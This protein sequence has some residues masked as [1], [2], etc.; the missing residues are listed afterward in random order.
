MQAELADYVPIQINMLH[1]LTM[2]QQLT[3]QLYY[4]EVYDLRRHPVHS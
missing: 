3:K 4:L 1:H 2:Q